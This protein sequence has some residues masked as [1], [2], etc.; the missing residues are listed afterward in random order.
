MAF[1]GKWLPEYSTV[2][3]GISTAGNW[4]VRSDPKIAILKISFTSLKLSEPV[5]GSSRG[6]RY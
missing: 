1:C 5:E 2:L 3:R 4:D 6:K